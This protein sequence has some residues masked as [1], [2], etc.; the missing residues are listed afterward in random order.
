VT[1]NKLFKWVPNTQRTLVDKLAKKKTSKS[2]ISKK[3]SS[4]WM[5]NPW[6]ISAAIM[7]FIFGFSVLGVFKPVSDMLSSSFSGMAIVPD[8]GSSDP[9]TLTI[10]SD[11]DCS[12]CD[13]S[14]GLAFF[15]QN[16]PG[17]EIEE[18]TY[19]SEFGE[20]LVREL[21]LEATPSFVFNEA[22]TD[23]AI[24][25]QIAT[26]FTKRGDYYE[27]MP[28]WIQRVVDPDASDV[29]INLVTE[30]LAPSESETTIL[31][32][33]YQTVTNAV[34]SIH[35]A[36]SATGSQLL[37]TYS[38]EAPSFIIP[39]G[40]MDS[41]INDDINTLLG[42]LQGN[43]QGCSKISSTSELKTQGGFDII[44][45]TEEETDAYSKTNEP[46]LEFYVMSF[47]PYGNQAED[48]LKPVYDLL[49]DY[50]LIEPHYIQG[51]DPSS[52]DGYKAL[53]GPQELHQNVRELCVWNYYDQDTW[54]DF[55]MDVNAD[56]TSQN[57]DSTWE[58]SATA[59]GIDVQVIKDC[60]EN[61]MSDLLDA[62]IALT[63]AYGVTGSP[64]FIINGEKY[65]GSR[66]SDA[67]KDALCCSFNDVPDE[68][69]Q[70]I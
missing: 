21:G 62:E 68:C 5:D 66:T 50:A 61:E 26:Y 57:A 67:V 51:P 34:L 16:I 13:Y 40:S 37:S 55:V 48:V 3:K 10:I 46:E 63:T 69:S 27:I 32:S 18:F 36:D 41:E 49:G 22:I 23:E 25:S 6:K 60:E 33:I 53:H 38:A 24:Y 56:S 43:V 44:S 58:Q 64:T 14:Q 12:L 2:K 28:I 29:E 15:E 17:L 4:P 59:N 70:V 54:W 1:S 9:V 19:Q 8:S 30:N 52:E 20:E 65:V 47:C 11:D 31:F 39:E 45:L 7:L 42:E 35:A